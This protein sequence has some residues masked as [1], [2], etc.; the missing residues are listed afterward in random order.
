VVP[1]TYSETRQMRPV[2]RRMQAPSGAGRL[3][4][5]NGRWRGARHIFRNAGGVPD[6][7]SETRQM[8]PVKRRMQAPSGAGR[9]L[10]PNGRGRMLEGSQLFPVAA[11]NLACDLHPASF[12]L[13]PLE[14][15]GRTILILR[16]RKV[17]LDS[18]LAALYGAS[19]KRLNEQ[20]K[21]NAERF[22]WRGA[23]HI[24]RG[25]TAKRPREASFFLTPWAALSKAPHQ[26]HYL[27]AR[28]CP[29]SGRRRKRQRSRPPATRPHPP[30]YCSRVTQFQICHWHPA[31]GSPSM[32][33]RGPGVGA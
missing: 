8:R 16:G 12:L 30:L 4:R 11:D 33:A 5:P 27:R 14:R 17:I 31:S 2:K 3:L 25:L 29:R 24:F 26:R 19:A 7:Y 28:C 15:V 21:R 9:L 18:E 10:G 13:V 20:V 23:R 32:A 6:T 22:R 1:D